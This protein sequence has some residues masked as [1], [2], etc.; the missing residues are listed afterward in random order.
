MTA[1]D[2]YNCSPFSR[3]ND[4]NSLDP[5]GF[6]ERFQRLGF[7]WVKSGSSKL[8]NAQAVLKFLDQ[9]SMI[10]ER[11]WTIENLGDCKSESK[12]TPSSVSTFSDQSFYVSTIVH[13]QDMNAL[14]Q[15]LRLLPDMPE[16]FQDLLV[17]GGAW[18]FVGHAPEKERKRKRSLLGRAEHVD[19]VG[20]SGTYHFQVSGTKIWWIRPHPELFESDLPD[21]ST[22]PEA[23]RSENTKSWRIKA[24]VEEGDIFVLNTK[25]WY[26]H[27]ELPQG[28]AW[29]ISIARD[30]YLPV[31]CPITASK[32]DAIFEE[33]EIPD[34]I[35][36]TEYPNCAL[37]E[38]QGDDTEE[39]KI[40]LVATQ[41]IK[42]GDF[43]SI[44]IENGDEGE[45]NADE[46]IDPRAVSN[47][48]WQEGE[49]VLLGDEIPDE[50]PRS[51][52][53]NCEL[54]VEG[55]AAQLRALQI[56]RK[57]DIFCI[58]PNEGEEYEE[59]VID[60]ASGELLR[61]NMK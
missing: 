16:P 48:T 30:F 32:G 6:L 35:P 23:E 40:I 4:L 28:E 22:I 1:S 20:H 29:S 36:Q 17:T 44:E 56:V 51:L 33:D 38:V 42:V 15:L 43:L 57:G 12:L 7:L 26:H 50:L 45:F 39:P 2:K 53:P 9:N 41:D 11:H 59:V 47:Q 49:V 27:T 5:D 25:I 61:D 54:V 19:E 52:D 8:P 21:L 10:C 37:V 55:E 13:R 18:L 31:P 58:L 34:D 14:Q 3:I 60:E 46:A 24:E